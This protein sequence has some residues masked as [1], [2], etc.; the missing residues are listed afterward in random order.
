MKKYNKLVLCVC[1]ILVIVLGFVLVGAIVRRESK[2]NNTETKAPNE[3]TWEEYQALSLEEKDAFYLRFDSKS[4][5]EEWVEFV[6]PVEKEPDILKWNESDKLPNEYTWEEYQ[7][8]S[9]E[10]KD[11]FR[12]NLHIQLGTNI[13]VESYLE[14][15][16]KS[17]MK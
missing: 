9:L 7:S 11:A 5:F 15:D 14:E 6:K 8:L 10:K 17:L 13:L 4:A 2:Q 3:Y 1:L 16:F 12:R